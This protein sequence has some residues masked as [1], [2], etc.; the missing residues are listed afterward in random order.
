MR[1]W[2]VP[3]RA[4][5]VHSGVSLSADCGGVA[6]GPPSQEDVERTRDTTSNTNNQQQPTTTN[7]SN[8]PNTSRFH[9]TPR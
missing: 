6:V 2:R 1:L 4:P 3:E 8:D 5:G 9:Q 7:N